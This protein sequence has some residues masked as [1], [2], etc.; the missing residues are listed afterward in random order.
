MLNIAIIV[1][2]TSFYAGMLMRTGLLEN[3][4]LEDV[5]IL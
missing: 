5:F 3:V 1:L 2:Q 4:Y